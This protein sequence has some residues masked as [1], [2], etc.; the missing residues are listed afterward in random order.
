MNDARPELWL[1]RHGETEW[2]R[3]SRHTSVTDVPLTQAG[4]RS[5]WELGDRLAGTSFDLVLSSPLS[6]A[7]Q[8]ARLAGFGDRIEIDPG[9]Q[10]WRYGDHEGRTTAQ[11]REDDP[12]WSV[13]THPSPG[14]E[15][16]EQVAARADLL[17]ARVRREAST[18]ALVFSHGHFLRVLGARWMDLPPRVG[19][20][21]VLDVATV[22]V[23]GW[24]RGETPAIQRWNA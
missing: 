3:A 22:S 23:L 16:L 17:I 6:R 20:N 7:R 24:E 15:T 11:I 12:D 19:A 1:A 10:E 13:W 2:S 21:L 5:A 9:A 8:T 18:R 4:E 14:G